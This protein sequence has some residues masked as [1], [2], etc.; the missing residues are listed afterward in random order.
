MRSTVAAV[1]LLAVL[2]LLGLTNP[3][4]E[5]FAIRYADRINAELAADLGLEGPVGDL[6]GG[7]TQRA[8]EGALVE[9]TRRSNYGIASVFTV[10]RGGEDLR[11]LGIAG[12]FVTLSGEGSTR[13]STPEPAL[14]A[15]DGARG[16]ASDPV[17][18]PPVAAVALPAEELAA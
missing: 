13:G 17:P 6:L 2:G 9:Q 7:L 5:Q 12:Q 15:I 16:A 4:T 18:T 3:T 8:I 10:P 1:L 14:G 11:V